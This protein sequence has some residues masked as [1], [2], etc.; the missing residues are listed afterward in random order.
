MLRLLKRAVQKA[1][2]TFFKPVLEGQARLLAQQQTILDNQNVLL[3]MQQSIAFRQ[4][5][6]SAP[7][8]SNNWFVVNIPA[9]RSL[10]GGPAGE[11]RSEVPRDRLL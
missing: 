7:L 4:L 5:G 10:A 11:T 3:E 9:W 8:F 6:W 2:R 1:R